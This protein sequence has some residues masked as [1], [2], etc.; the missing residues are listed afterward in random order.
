MPVCC[1]V[2][3]LA[4]QVAALLEQQE[5]MRNE[6][7]AVRGGGKTSGAAPTASSTAHP[8]R[9]GAASAPGVRAR[10][11]VPP[12]ARV[13]GGGG[14]VAPKPPPEAP[15]PGS[16]AYNLAAAAKRRGNAPAFGSSSS[17]LNSQN[18]AP[19][20][21]AAAAKRRAGAQQTPHRLA[22]VNEGGDG[23][24]ELMRRSLSAPP[25]RGS[26]GAV[27]AQQGARGGNRSVSVAAAG[28]RAGQPTTYCHADDEYDDGDVVSERG[29]EVVRLSGGRRALLPKAQSARPARGHQ[30]RVAAR[31]S[32]DE[33]DD[34]GDDD[35]VDLGH[36]PRVTNGRRTWSAGA[37]GRLRSP[38]VNG[39]SEFLYP[40][41]DIDGGALPSARSARGAVDDDNLYAPHHQRSPQVASRRP[42]PARP[43]PP[44]PMRAQSPPIQSAY[45]RGGARAS[46]SRFAVGGIDDDPNE[47]RGTSDA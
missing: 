43:Q 28:R 18:V 1:A 22:A 8:R 46:A 31:P 30:P 7:L 20:Q 24:E 29:E 3:Q 25:R 11:L 12:P 27:T 21:A 41:D 38:E 15:V 32:H 13:S 35:N 42:P 6:L 36:A 47:F 34:G 2:S 9:A 44:S 10:A 4:K 39:S 5:R 17:R 45:T 19:G 37:A 40:Q 26:V 33:H 14:G 23:D 16:I